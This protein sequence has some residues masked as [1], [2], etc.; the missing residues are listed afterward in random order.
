MGSKDEWESLQAV[1]EPVPNNPNP[2]PPVPCPLLSAE[3]M[4]VA[5]L[6]GVPRHALS[7]H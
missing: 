7:K 5:H 2:E 4:F 6:P 1:L 3:C